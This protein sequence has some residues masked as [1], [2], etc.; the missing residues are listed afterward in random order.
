MRYLI[1]IILLTSLAACKTKTMDKN[2]TT[3]YAFRLKPG[4][5]LKAGIEQVVKERQIR[6]GRATL[7]S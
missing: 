4:D 6:A 2:Q 7:R 3:V 5:D 1:Y